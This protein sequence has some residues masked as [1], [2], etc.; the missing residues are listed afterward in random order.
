[1]QLAKKRFKITPGVIF[2]FFRNKTP[3]KKQD[4]PQKLFLED[5]VLLTAKGF[6]PLRTC[7]NVWMWRLVLRLDPKMVF[8]FRNTLSEEIL[9]KMV[10]CCL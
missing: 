7:E 9:P 4:G 2:I 8:P 3:Y 6:F 10:T 1:M 5:L